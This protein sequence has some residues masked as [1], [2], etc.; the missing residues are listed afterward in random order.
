LGT[1]RS[2][3]R[4]PGITYSGLIGY[5]ALYAD[6]AQGQGRRRYEFDMLQHGPVVGISL[7]W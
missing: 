4:A 3:I 7:R 5:K 2:E 6:Y 1:Y